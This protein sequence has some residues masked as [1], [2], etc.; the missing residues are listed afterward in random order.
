VPKP[1]FHREHQD[2]SEDTVAVN[3]TLMTPSTAPPQVPW[4]HSV[5]GADSPG[6]RY[7]YS[8]AHVRTTRANIAEEQHGGIGPR[9]RTSRSERRTATTC[10][11]RRSSVALAEAQAT[12]NGD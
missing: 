9:V 2:R 5:E 11:L 8:V 6:Q 3:F 4:S 7:M 10:K 12:A 1:P